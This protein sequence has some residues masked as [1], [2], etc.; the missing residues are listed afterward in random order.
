MEDQDPTAM[1][2]EPARAEDL[3]LEAEAGEGAP[4]DEELFEIE[5]DGQVYAVP[6]SLKGAF[7][8]HADY[9]RKTQ[10]LAE[11]RRS[12]EAE[13]AAAA[14]DRKAWAQAS[15]DRATL[16]ALDH[17]LETYAGVD[18]QAF[19]RAEPERAKALWAQFQQTRELRGDYA[20]ALSRHESRAEIEAAREAA[21]QM[22]ATGRLLSQEIDGWS[23]ETAGKL[24]AYAEA[25]GVTPDELAQ[26]ADAR[27]WKL[28]HKAWKADE[29]ARGET[30]AQAQA[31][32]P[33]VQV[34]GGAAGA[35]G[36]RDEL[37]TK[38]WMRRR[39]EHT[40]RGR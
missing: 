24:V 36:V 22:A 12:V 13:R 4:Q 31:L 32:R 17:Q 11:H 30:V 14:A 25:F 21:E 38:E 8:R 28:L 5:L 26:V 27:L 16:A 9:T 39:N 37:G 33:A 35:G 34:T 15:N 23:P 19:A 1:G 3:A 10:D 2:D 20:Q 7:L 29:A 40:Q 18:W 6:G